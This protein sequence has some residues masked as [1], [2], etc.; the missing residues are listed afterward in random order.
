MHLAREEGTGAGASYIRNAKEREHEV[1]GPHIFISKQ[2]SLDLRIFESSLFEKEFSQ[3][4]IMIRTFTHATNVSIG[5]V[6]PTP[7]QIDGR[8]F[9]LESLVAHK[10]RSNTI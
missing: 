10:V 5:P 9:K 2:L 1:F 4:S 8:Q 6:H 7:L 3:H